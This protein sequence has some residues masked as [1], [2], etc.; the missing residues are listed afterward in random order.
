V[1]CTRDDLA[2]AIATDVAALVVQGGWASQLVVDP[3]AGSGNTLY[4]LLRKLPGARA[5]A[6]EN[7]PLVH[8]LSARNLALLDLPLRLECLDYA[9]GLEQIRA[10]PGELVLAI[11]APPWGR[12]LDAT[13]GLDLGRTEPPIAHI[14]ESFARHFE[15]N[16]M[17]FAIQVH[18]R[19]EP[20]SLARLVSR[21]D[22]FEHKVYA[23]NRAGQNHGT[24]IGSVGWTP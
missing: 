17:L 16:P 6:F 11:I 13:L 8:E 22:A 2:S 18:E 21:F 5:I 14:V 20:E 10:A 3:F 12:A 4:W 23:L 7:D 9:S 1:E 24:L 15:A 19:V